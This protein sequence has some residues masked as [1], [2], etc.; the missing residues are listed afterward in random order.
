MILIRGIL[1]CTIMREE[2][3]STYNRDAKIWRPP[4]IYDCG[5]L[6]L[7]GAGYFKEKL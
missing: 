7:G 4:E 2:A 3:N 6:Y 5:R 1:L